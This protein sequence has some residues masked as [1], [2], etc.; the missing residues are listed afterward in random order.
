MILSTY[1]KKL[2]SLLAAIGVILGV[3]IA[4]LYL[5]SPTI[6]LFSI[7]MAL[8]LSCSLYLIIIYSQFPAYSLQHITKNGKKL[9]DITFLLLFS[10]SLIITHNLEYRPLV[11]FLLYSLCAGSIAVSIY[12]SNTKIDYFIQYLK[13]ILLSFN[14]KYSIF[15]LAG[16]IPGVDP[17]THAKMNSLLSQTGNIG[18]LYDKEIYFP[19]MHIQ[20]VIME[21]LT[22]TSLRDASNFAIIIP[23]VFASSFVYL[24]SKDLLGHR[25]GLF[26]MLLVNISDYH[27]YWGSSPQTTSYGLILYYLLVYILVK[28]YFLNC[29][30]KWV[31]ISILLSFILIITHA[32]SSFI[33]LITTASLFLGT[34]FYN[35]LY[36]EW[37]IS[38]LKNISLITAI[39]LLQQ[40]FIAIYS[41]DGRP[42]FDVI[43]ST[44]YFYI[45]GHAEF[46]N[47][48]ETISAFSATMP[49]FLERFADICGFSLFLF[50]GIIGSLFCLSDKHRSRDIFS[51]IFVLTVLFSINFSFPLFGI[52]NIMPSRWFAFEYLFLSTLAS[53]SI[54]KLST[55]FKSR[56][57]RPIFVA[58]VFISIAFF[59]STS[60]ISNLD[61]PL[62][63]KTE[64][65]S[66]TY[67]LGEVRGAETLSKFGNNFLSDYRFGET[68]IS[69]YF[70]KKCIILDSNEN[71][72][73]GNIFI[74]RSHMEQRPIGRYT[75]LK[76]YYKPIV[77]TIVLGKDFHSKLTKYN[78]IYYNKDISAYYIP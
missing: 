4:L 15:N 63:L 44:L 55:Y 8:T 65:V 74:W 12:F 59:M 38:K 33:F 57:L 19:I 10:L 37:K 34:I 69:L 7:G 46:L 61:S 30:Y 32:V 5:V 49:P 11:Y 39:M 9:L 35:F 23:F 70:E 53:F 26:A 16:F 42:F 58:V 68:V 66:T 28:S 75:L 41:T 71:L 73:H 77:S 27:I 31:A 3:L 54:L 21:L 36:K 6:H 64:T 40:W 78:K 76:G 67:T 45:T 25:A 17:W 47:R 60:T 2:D 48:P 22:N 1:F 14:I 24:V 18:V 72:G 43:V 52:R 13:I 51:F 20:T 50:F 62:W 56:K 29:N